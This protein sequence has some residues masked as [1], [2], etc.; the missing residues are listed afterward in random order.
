M[1]YIHSHENLMLEC[2]IF[3]LHI[4]KL[5]RKTILQQTPSS[6]TPTSGTP[7]SFFSSTWYGGHP[8]KKKEQKKNNKTNKLKLSKALHHAQVEIS[9]VKQVVDVIK[10][11]NN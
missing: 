3:K 11:A 6:D 9:L 7:T 10:T 5:H 8:W 2:W 1:L 4:L